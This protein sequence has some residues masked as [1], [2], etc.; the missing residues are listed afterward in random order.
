MIWAWFPAACYDWDL[1]E[2]FLA[3]SDWEWFASRELHP[4]E[5]LSR[6]RVLRGDEPDA[7]V[8]GTYHKTH[9]VYAFKKLFR[10]VLGVT[11]ADNYLLTSGHMHHCSGNT[12]IDGWGTTR[13]VAKWLDCVA[14]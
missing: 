1:E 10:S 7:Y 4:D 14:L 3:E 12:L 9:C 5:K 11:L 8:T 13:G 2:Q 6:E